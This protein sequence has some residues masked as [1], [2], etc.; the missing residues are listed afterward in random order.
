[1]FIHERF[2]R[3]LNHNS[4]V[5]LCLALSL[6]PPDFGHHLRNLRIFLTPFV[7]VHPR[8][9]LFEIL[10]VDFP[11]HFKPSDVMFRAEA[12]ILS[13]WDNEFLHNFSCNLFDALCLHLYVVIEVD[14]LYRI[15]VDG[16]DHRIRREVV[17]VLF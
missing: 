3:I 7:Q 5:L 16:V 17:L 14:I 2:N 1:M 11:V 12:R 6:R 4:H 8:L 9:N 10:S 15:G 13:F